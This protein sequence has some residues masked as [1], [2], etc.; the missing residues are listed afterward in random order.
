[1][2]HRLHVDPSLAETFAALRAEAARLPEY[3]EAR[4]AA[5][6]DLAVVIAA[7]T[8][9]ER[10]GRTLVLLGHCPPTP[11]FRG[12]G[13]ARHHVRAA[14]EADLSAMRAEADALARRL[15][16]ADA[17]LWPDGSVEHR[18]EIERLM[19]LVIEDLLK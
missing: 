19:S 10:G 4:A 17:R 12:V 13:E 11:P 15:G 7:G 14:W 16:A 18:R 6:R 9:R 3:Q 2:Y 1:M 8:L 5:V